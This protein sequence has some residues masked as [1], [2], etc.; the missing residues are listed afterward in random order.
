MKC[1]AV[2]FI[3]GTIDY[4]KLKL[5][6]RREWS[7]KTENSIFPPDLSAFLLLIFRLSDAR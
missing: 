3:I 5:L 1:L 7:L 4:K 6:V 2:S